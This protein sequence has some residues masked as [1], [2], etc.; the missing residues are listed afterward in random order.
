[1]IV[2]ITMTIIVMITIVILTMIR[3]ALR[4]ALPSPA[5]GLEAEVAALG[6]DKPPRALRH[7]HITLTRY[8]YVRHSHTH[9]HTH[10]CRTC[11]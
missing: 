7:Q 6:A 11:I 1:M 10:T 3:Q 2:R 8:M 9:T 4:P 5:L